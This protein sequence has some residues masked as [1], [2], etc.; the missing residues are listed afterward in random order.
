MKITVPTQLGRALAALSLTLGYGYNTLVAGAELAASATKTLTIP[1]AQPT[2]A[3]PAPADFVSPGFETAFADNFANAFSANLVAALAGRMSLPP[4]IRVGGTS[5]DRVQFD[6]NLKSANKVCVKGECPLGSNAWFVLGPGYFDVF[7]GFPDAKW[8]FQAPLGDGVYNETQLLAYVERVWDAAGK[9]RVDAI[10]LGNEPSVYWKT[11]KEYYDG[12][13]KVQAAI[14]KALGLGDGRIFEIGDTLS[15]AAA[16]HKPYAVQEM[17]KA[18]FDSD[19]KVKL[20]AEHF[21]QGTKTTFGIDAL[22]ADLMNHTA[23]KNKFN[24]L[25]SSINAVQPVNG[26]SYILSETGSSIVKDVVL[27][28]TSGFGAALWSVDF[29]LAAM[30]RRIRRIV[31]SGRPVAKHASW[32]PDDSGNN[33]GPAVRPPFSANMFVADFI[34]KDKARSVLSV[35]PNQELVSAYVMYDAASKKPDRVALTNLKAWD[36]ASGEARGAQAFVVPVAAGTA[37]VKVR[38][39]HSDAGVWAMGFDTGGAKENVTWAGEQW[40]YKVDKGKGHFVGGKLQEQT[41][42]VQDGK[43]VVNVPDSE[44]VI[45]YL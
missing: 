23:I 25:M 9:D 22:Q 7:K 28:Y 5:G 27:E 16:S 39:F 3:V 34:G 24:G 41:V 40:T 32:V 2:G 4:V 37:S 26:V 1:T 33:G 30:T 11:A 29:Q 17:L 43:A 18:G 14:V 42:A 15:G 44:A 6:P 36:G 12:A 35:L 10:A 13:T 21:Y 31:D 45:V 20:A 38:R 8:S 19:A